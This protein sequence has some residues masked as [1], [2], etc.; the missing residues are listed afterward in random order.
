[1]VT[2][3]LM[4]GFEYSST[5]KSGYEQYNLYKTKQY[6]DIYKARAGQHTSAT[7]I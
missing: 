3:Q 7:I 6:Y 4:I 1:M 2:N 5:H